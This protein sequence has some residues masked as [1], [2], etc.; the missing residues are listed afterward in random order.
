[1]ALLKWRELNGQAVPYLAC[2][3]LHVTFAPDF[4]GTPVDVATVALVV[5]DLKTRQ[6]FTLVGTST[7]DAGYALSRQQDLRPVPYGHRAVLKILQPPAQNEP[8][9][10]SRCRSTS[11]RNGPD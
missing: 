6:P 8:R 2:V 3:N 4:L 11:W 1:M 9:E 5:P 10:P 7:P